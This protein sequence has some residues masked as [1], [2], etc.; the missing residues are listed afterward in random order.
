MVN[1]IVKFFATSSRGS[2]RGVWMRKYCTFKSQSGLSLIEVL[3]A[4]SLAVGVGFISMDA[5]ETTNKQ[6]KT[7]Q[8]YLTASEIRNSLQTLLREKS[9]L[10]EKIRNHIKN[11][12]TKGCFPKSFDPDPASGDP[13]FSGKCSKGETGITLPKPDSDQGVFIGK[14]LGDNV[15]SSGDTNSPTYYNYN[16]EVCTNPERQSCSLAM[17]STLISVC[18]SPGANC[19]NGP[20][21]IKIK[22]ELRDNRAETLVG[23]STAKKVPWAKK[24]SIYQFSA[25]HDLTFLKASATEKLAS[26]KCID[27]TINGVLS[28]GYPVKIEDGKIICGYHDLLGYKGDKGETGIR[29][30]PGINGTNGRTGPRGPTGRSCTGYRQGSGGCDANGNNCPR[31]WRVVCN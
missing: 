1:M 3:T 16:G 4:I 6:I 22:V 19:L 24:P 27:R 14:T 5:Q 12:A 21:L 30:E 23:T 9:Y 15:I 13:T 7:I 8:I 25:L 20:D 28:R 26:Q 10:T 29:G 17:V 11:I 2:V 31:S 18:G